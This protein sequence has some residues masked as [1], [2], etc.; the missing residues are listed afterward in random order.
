MAAIH[1]LLE[2]GATLSVRVTLR[3]DRGEKLTWDKRT[4]LSSGLLKNP[5]LGGS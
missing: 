4:M 3:W 1:L 2:G 5:V